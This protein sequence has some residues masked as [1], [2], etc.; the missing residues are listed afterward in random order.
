MEP[1]LDNSFLPIKTKTSGAATNCYGVG[2]N[3]TSLD[4]P[5]SLLAEATMALD[6]ASRSLSPLPAISNKRSPSSSTLMLQSTMRLKFVSI[7][8]LASSVF[9]CAIAVY[10]FF[11]VVKDYRLPTVTFYCC[12]AGLWTFIYVMALI[13]PLVHRHD[14]YVRA[15][16]WDLDNEHDTTKGEPAVPPTFALWAL[17]RADLV[18][19]QPV[20]D[21]LAGVSVE[22]AVGLEDKEV[23]CRDEEGVVDLEGGE[24]GGDLL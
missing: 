2:G 4:V 19:V 8:D 12:I 18:E 15:S 11:G 10:T 3:L 6:A 22:H 24:E 23:F 1:G 14:I 20:V 13:G 9:I 16:A 17:G 5:A 21:A 7:G